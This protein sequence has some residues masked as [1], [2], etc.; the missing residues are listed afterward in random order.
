VGHITVF[1]RV[2]RKVITE[3]TFVFRDNACFSGTNE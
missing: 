3:V 2:V 1:N